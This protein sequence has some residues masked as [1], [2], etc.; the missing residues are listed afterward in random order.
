MIGDILRALARLLTPPTFPRRNPLEPL[1]FHEVSNSMPAAGLPLRPQLLPHLRASIDSGM[2]RMDGMNLLH[3]LSILHRA[4]AWPTQLSRV[5]ATRRDTS[6]STHHPNR[7]SLA[8]AGNHRISRIVSLAKNAAAS[9]KKSLSR[10]TR[11][12]S[13]FRWT[14]SSSRGTPWP[15]NAFIPSRGCSRHHR[16][17][18]LV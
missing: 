17:S 18:T 8:A 9:F 12:H 6:Q 15:R 5:I 16:L 1:L 11:A 7:Y 4:W 13:R 14:S 3:E 10:F 2:L